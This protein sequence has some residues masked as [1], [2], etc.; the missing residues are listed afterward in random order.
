MILMSGTENNYVGVF[1]HKFPF[2]TGL[3]KDMVNHL[4]EGEDVDV[5]SFCQQVFRDKQGKSFRYLEFTEIVHPG[6]REGFDYLCSHLELTVAEPKCVI[7][8]GQWVAK[9]LVYERYVKEILIPA[10]DFMETDDKMKQLAWKDSQYDKRGGLKPEVLK[11]YTGL[12]YY[13]MACFLLERLPS[14]VID[15]WNLTFKVKTTI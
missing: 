12:D 9:Q 15:N 3:S 14:I 10:M 1:S 8:S 11:K 5:I 7:Y 4:I 2:K 13:P 6:F